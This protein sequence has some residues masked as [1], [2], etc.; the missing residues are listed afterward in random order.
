M[1]RMI[2]RVAAPALVLAAW[3]AAAEPVTNPPPPALVT[4]FAELKHAQVRILAGKLNLPIPP[5]VTAFFRAAEKGPFDVVSNRFERLLN[6]RDNPPVQPAIRNALWAPVHETVGAWEEWH[7]WKYNDPLLKMFYEPVL[8]SL[9]EGSVYFGGTDF[10][11]FV[12]TAAAEVRRTPTLHCM[13]Q[14]ALADITYTAF[15]RAAHGDALWI[16]DDTDSA[17]AFQVYM[18]DVQAGRRPKNSEITISDGKVRISGAMGVMEINGIIARMIF[19]RNKDKHEFYVQESY[20][21]PWMY[22]YLTPHGLIM[23]LNP[24][25]VPTLPPETVRRDREFWANQVRRLFAHRA[26]ARNPDAR[27]A[28]SKLRSAIAGLYEAR[29]MTDEAEA[30]YREAQQLYPPSPEANLRLAKLF[31]NLGQTNKACEVMQDFLKMAPSN[32]AARVYLDRLR[33][34]GKK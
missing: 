16:P 14:N 26:F 13:T 27:I 4:A 7:K 28:F 30:A 3:T 10:G 18:D 6:S 9:P 31:E 22:P 17:R 20:V 12:I 34:E 33:P 24:E 8:Q 11:R 29:G 2:P 19:E 23:K 25:P 5:D 21:I 15:L 1:K 32:Q